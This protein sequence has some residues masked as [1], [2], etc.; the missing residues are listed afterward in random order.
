[1]CVDKYGK[2]DDCKVFREFLSDECGEM[3]RYKWIESEKA[4]YDLGNTAVMDWIKKYA[5]SYRCWWVNRHNN[6]TRK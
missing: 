1:M 2:F 4:G 3:Q 5:A 6:T